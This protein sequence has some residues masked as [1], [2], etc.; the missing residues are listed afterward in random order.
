MKKRGF[1]LIELMVVIAII[2]LLAAIALPKFS[3]VSSQ[4]KVANVQG[5]LSSLRTSIAM[6]YAKTEAYPNL[7]DNYGNLAN[8]KT[9]DASG[10]EVLFTEVYGKTEMPDTPVDNANSVVATNV[11]VSVASSTAT[12]D[13]DGGWT[14]YST[15]GTIRADLPANA[16]VTGSNL[17]D[18]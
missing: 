11:T 15:D 12:G 1:T 18:F 8:A 9:N 10:T 3:D 5:N 7:V 13:S 14:Y 16:Y 4:A 17:S 2:G 6:F